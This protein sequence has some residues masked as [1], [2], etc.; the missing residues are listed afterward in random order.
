[1]APIKTRPTGEDV[2]AFLDSVPDERRRA[3]GHEIRAIFERI[4]ATPAAMWGPSMVGFGSAPYTNTTGTNDW[5]IVAFSPRRDA[6]TLYGIYDGYEDPD[7]R[8]PAFAGRLTPAELGLVI[9]YLQGDY[10][11][12]AAGDDEAPAAAD[13]ERSI[14]R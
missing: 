14:R 12:A 13:R 4:T 5:P 2:T 10:I 9:K 7:A 6:L 1:M 11:P 8:M 3:E